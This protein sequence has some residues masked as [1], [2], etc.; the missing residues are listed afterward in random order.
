ME[1]DAV[2][3]FKIALTIVPTYDGNP[4]QLFRFITT[5]E[6]VLTQ[7]YNAE[8]PDNF[9]NQIV[10]QNIL[11]KLRGRAE[12]V[13]NIHGSATWASV[14]SVLLQHFSDQ[15]DENALNRDL[16]NL[17]QENETPQQFYTRCMQLLNTIINYVSLHENDQNLQVGKRTFF[18]AQAL[19]TF[20]AGLKEPLGST[21]RAMRPADMPT[22]LTFIKEEQNIQYLQKKSH[23]IQVVSK[24][25]NQ[26]KMPIAFKNFQFNRPNNAFQN[27]I[28]FTPIPFNQYPFRMTHVS[29]PRPVN[30]FNNNSIRM[31]QNHFRN[32]QSNFTPKQNPQPMSGISYRSA[33]I[34][35]RPMFNQNR[36]YFEPV[37][38]NPN[39]NFIIEEVHNTEHA[40][41]GVDFSEQAYSEAALSASPTHTD[42]AAGFAT[43]N[44]TEQLDDSQYYSN[45]SD[46]IQSVSKNESENFYDVSIIKPSF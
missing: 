2:N 1:V 11:G 30:N 40:H 41:L 18:T 45:E 28:P 20:L 25:T 46:M 8:E 15:R 37:V 34:P 7:F 4:N 14:K 17:R 36:N 32:N 33:Q 5:S 6:T 42:N 19:K 38:Q 10:L 21:I 12:E 31:Q 29:Q 44:Y 39:S 22:A 23:D 3:L 26:T 35:L 24:P 27:N 43:A 13:I 16:V 9:Q